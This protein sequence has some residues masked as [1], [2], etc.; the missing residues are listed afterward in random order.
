MSMALN[1]P[2]R[3]MDIKDDMTRELESRWRCL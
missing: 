1:T 2:D 3:A